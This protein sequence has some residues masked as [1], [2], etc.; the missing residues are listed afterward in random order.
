MTNSFSK[1]STP[2]EDDLEDNQYDFPFNDYDE[3]ELYCDYIDYTEQS[4]D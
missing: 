2:Q 3:Y 1:V 4:Y